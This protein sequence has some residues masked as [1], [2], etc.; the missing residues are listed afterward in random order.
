MA[1]DEVVPASQPASPEDRLQA[2]EAT[3]V[4]LQRRMGQME[5][6]IFGVENV[7]RA[8]G[9]AAAS[10][11]AGDQTPTTVNVLGLAGRAFLI[12]GGAFLIR[13]LTEGGT[14]PKGLGVLLG[15]LYAA[16][17]AIAALRSQGAVASLYTVLSAFLIYPLLF[18]ST[19]RFG[20]LSPLLAALWI[21][22]ST[23]G[24]LWIS[25]R[26]DLR[27]AAWVALLTSLA[28][29]FALMA[30]TTAPIPY[31]ALFLAIGGCILWL[32]Y[33]R[34]WHGLRWPAALVADLAVL[35]LTSIAATPGGPPEA[36]RDLSIGGSM[37]LALGLVVVYVGS[38]AAR[39]LQKN[40][41]V[42]VFEITQSSLAVVVGFGGAIRIALASGSTL[43][44]FGI[45][46]LIT[47]LACYG[48]AFAFMEKEEDAVVNFFF[49]TTLALVFTLLGSILVVPRTGLV[50]TLATLGTLSLILGVRQNRWI[51]RTHGAVYYSSMA[52]TL[53]IPALAGAAFWGS[54][55][56]APLEQPLA[57]AA[58]GGGMALAHVYTA[59]QRARTPL[60]WWRKLPSFALALWAGLGL[61]SLV[62]LGTAR[63][64]PEP[65]ALAALRT[66]ILALVT[67]GAAFLPR[68]V[69]TS[70]TWW[71]V[72]PLLG[73]TALKVLLQD[74]PAGK[75]L[76]LA[77][78]FACFGIALVVAPRI[79]KGS[80][81]AGEPAPT[82][83]PT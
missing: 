15:I 48:V 77:I 39:T 19:T 75:P 11:I 12:L 38:I 46:A 14:L 16:V 42:N 58:F 29:G 44:P 23:A 5:V 83:S 4:D 3:L 76:P 10:S 40:R 20:V 7:Q 66:A 71:L 36:Y 56:L 61:A 27:T 31:T 50:P 45:A 79:L 8:P 57:L 28:T 25:W 34:K 6:A 68:W 9:A 33:G 60:V 1:K 32:T 82:S 49:F 69:P 74:L 43:I 80:R 78:T 24:L 52:I 55:P 65:S 62:V 35:V 73:L 47:G 41:K 22:A 54:L 63:A 26:G 51:L 53:G 17:W 18:E 70:E 72:Y 37:A 13:A 81:P 59:T 30:T 64:F 67:V 2:L 21:G